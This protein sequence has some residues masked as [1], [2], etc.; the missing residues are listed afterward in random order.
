[1]LES[2][3]QMCTDQAKE[4]TYLGHHNN[5]HGSGSLASVKPNLATRKK[6]SL[7]PS[8]TGSANSLSMHP[9]KK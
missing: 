2:Q 6:K 4:R 8:Q 9:F 3:L 5:L 7:T 1:M